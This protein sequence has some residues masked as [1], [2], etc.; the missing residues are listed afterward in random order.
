VLPSLPYADNSHSSAESEAVLNAL[1]S[2]FNS[3]PNLFPAS[4]WGPVD[5]KEYLCQ[6]NEWV[7]GILSVWPELGALIATTSL[8][9][10]YF[11][12]LLSIFAICIAALDE[13]AQK[14]CLAE[15]KFVAG[16]LVEPVSVSPDPLGGAG[17]SPSFLSGLAADV[18]AAISTI[19]FDGRDPSDALAK[20]VAIF[21][22]HP[23][24]DIAKPSPTLNDGVAGIISE[25]TEMVG[26][27]A[28]KKEVISLANFIKVQR[29]R[30]AKGLKQLPISLHLVFS[31]SPGTGK[32]T[33]ARIVARL[34]KAL[35]VLAK[36]HL[37]E[38]DR[39]GLVSQYVGATAI[40]TKEAVESALDG[41]L[42]IDEAYSLYKETSWGD[43]G[44][45]AVET[46]LKLMEDYR[47][48]PAPGL[49]DT[50]LS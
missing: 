26:L 24:S 10:E 3:I 13:H 2:A 23:R 45:E 40:K 15:L 22:F 31:G 14:E 28:V 18:S 4:P 36:G 46:L 50:R 11:R 34:Y 7:F 1:A 41:V 38:V 25:L 35:G 43:V 32:T 8:G 44:S 17:V 30:E 5:A 48:W 16:F 33:V 42:F 29:L 20:F 37:V 49:V 12:P 39:S 21:L 6:L 27:N 9:E 19:D 47:D